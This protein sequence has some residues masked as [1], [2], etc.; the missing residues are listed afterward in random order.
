MFGRTVFQAFMVLGLTAALL[1][2]GDKPTPAADTSRCPAFEQFKRLAGD[3][4]GKEQGKDGHEIHVRYKV[5][6]AGSAVV[7]TILPGTEH[8]MVSVIHPDGADL[9]LTHYCMLGN[10][11]QMKA[12]APVGGTVEFK[13]VRATN[14]KS[15]KAM[16]MHDATFTFVDADTLR[17]D[18][19][20]FNDGK[21]SGQVVFD[22]KRKSPA[23]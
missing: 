12:T 4:A 10:Q 16:Y 11:P 20:H 7:E 5:T 18:W 22:L 14:L 3:W 15:E 1:P 23:R 2:A 6:A 19:T 9:V 17:T 13:F 21:P 8:E